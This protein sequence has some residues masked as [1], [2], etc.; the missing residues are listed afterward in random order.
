MSGTRQLLRVLL[1]GW[2]AAGA[3][4][5]L[6]H[7]MDVKV[8][9]TGDQITGQVLYSD[10]R[11]GVGDF[12]SVANVTSPQLLPLEATTDGDG[13]FAVTGI[14][15]NQYTVTAHGEEGH[16]VQVSLVLGGNALLEDAGVPFFVIAGALLLL[17]ILPARYLGKASR[18]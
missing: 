14:P 12:V 3:A 15:G 2:L 6:A 11:P 13:R 5:A 7:G 9:S 16:T 17:S 4:L 10:G 1:S 18:S 8:T